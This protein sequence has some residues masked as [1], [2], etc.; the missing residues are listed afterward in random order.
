[1][2]T[3]AR[4]NFH[5]DVFEWN[6]VAWLRDDML[7]VLFSKELFVGCVVLSGDITVFLIATMIDEG[8]NGHAARQLRDAANVIAMIVRDQQIIDPLSARELCGRDDALGIAAILI[9]P[10][11]VHQ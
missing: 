8:S 3:R 2:F 4:K 9:R 6:A 10:S 5:F 11:C 1:M 7:R